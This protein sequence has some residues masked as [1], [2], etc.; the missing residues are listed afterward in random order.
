MAVK[1]NPTRDI[2][3]GQAKRFSGN[4]L[5][6]ATLQ[7]AGARYADFLDTGSLNDESGNRNFMFGVHTFDDAG[8]VF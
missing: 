6:V 1:S 7:D 8:K 5:P 3:E 2:A 4:R